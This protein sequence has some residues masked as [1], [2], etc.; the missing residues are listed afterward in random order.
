M[1]YGKPCTCMHLYNNTFIIIIKNTFYKYILLIMAIVFLGII[2]NTQNIFWYK[3]NKI[4]KQSSQCNMEK[5]NRFNKK[6]VYRRK[7][8]IM[9]MDSSL[10]FE[11]NANLE[12]QTRVIYRIV[13][14][15]LLQHHL[16]E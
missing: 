16:G 3:K 13:P 1:S 9:I 11:E 6:N 7:R 12:I 2:E 10:L 14:F 5:K 8:N 4:F 15:P